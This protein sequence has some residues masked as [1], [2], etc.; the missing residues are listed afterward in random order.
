MRLLY[1]SVVGV[2]LFGAAVLFLFQVSLDKVRLPAPVPAGVS[3]PDNEIFD[4]TQACGEEAE[5]F[6]ES[7]ETY[8]G[9]GG[10]KRVLVYIGKNHA[11][12]EFWFM[13]NDE[14]PK[15]ALTAVF[16]G[17]ADDEMSVGALH[18]KLP[19]T[20]KVAFRLWP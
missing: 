20:A 13:R 6:S 7:A 9:A 16:L 3:Q 19:C 4:L 5:A 15:W 18:A 1:A 10:E 14:E 8:M 2:V 11:R 12:I 17:K